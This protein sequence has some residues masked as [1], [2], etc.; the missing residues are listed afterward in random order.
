[1]AEQQHTPEPWVRDGT[2][3]APDKLEID[4]RL[5]DEG[6]NWITI[7]GPNAEANHRRVL[8]CVNACKGIPTADLEM[9]NTVPKGD[10]CDWIRLA[11]L[12]GIASLT[13]KS[14][15]ATIDPLTT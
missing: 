6:D 7:K 4:L 13:C 14:V 1:M 11:A 9:L 12:S 2:I 3:C 15:R 5:D 8:A 10:A